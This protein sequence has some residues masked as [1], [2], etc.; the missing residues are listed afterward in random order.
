MDFTPKKDTIL[1]ADLDGTLAL[2]KS[3]ITPKMAEALSTWLS[4]G[5]F[6]VISGGAFEQFEKQIISHLPSD[7]NLENLSLFPTNGASCYSYKNGAWVALY[8][9]TLSDEEKSKITE[10]LTSAFEQATISIEQ[11]YGEQIEYRGGQVTF[12]ALGQQAPLEAKAPWDPD[13]AKRKRVVS[14]LAPLLPEFSISIGGTTSIDITKKGI[15]KAYAIS[16]IEHLFNVTSED[17]VFLGDA[18]FPG[19]NDWAVES[20]G[21]HCIKVSG[22]EESI[23]II[24][25]LHH[26]LSL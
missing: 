25:E 13:Q 10:A 18:L 15:D 23:S 12:S 8:N 3:S 14:I 7:T 6:A 16:K 11:T 17:I 4:H 19:G 26:S 1:A 9:E 22:P 5:R 21:A 20:T 24:L 2:S